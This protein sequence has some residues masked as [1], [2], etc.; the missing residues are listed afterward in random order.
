MLGPKEFL[1][2]TKIVNIV[3]FTGTA[4]FGTVV[5]R[6]V[7]FNKARFESHWNNKT[8][9][10]EILLKVKYHKQTDRASLCP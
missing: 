2:E 5:L 1:L 8:D 3:I 9:I 7:C 10:A 4:M 6:I